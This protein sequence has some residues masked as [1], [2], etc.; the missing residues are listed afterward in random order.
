MS[1]AGPHRDDAGP[2]LLRSVLFV[3]GNDQRK[4]GKAGAT[5]ADLVVID[6]EDA[7]AESEKTAARAIARQAVAAVAADAPAA[8]RVNGIDSGRLADDVAAVAAAELAAIV[9]PKVESAGALE[10]AEQALERAERD[11]G[12][13]AGRIGLIVLLETPLGIARCEEILLSAP[14]RTIAAMFGVADF[15]AALGVEV[16]ED[17]TELL[18]ARGRLVVAARAAG[19][20]GPID[21]PFLRIDDIPRLLTDSRRSRALGFEGRVALHPSQVEPIN[22]AFSELSDEQ[23]ATATRIVQAFEDA[24][25][26]GVASIRVDGSFVD[27]PVYE[28]ARARLR[29]HTAYAHGRDG[30]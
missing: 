16:T 15:S 2:R 7:V 26:S 5:G 20:P 8:V 19:L 4:L 13:A 30:D 14:S 12:L 24:E 21:G 6:L 9:V 25:A 18:F 1:G 10:A 23:L 22:R 3:P 27:Y 28:L 17:G 11:R 29:R